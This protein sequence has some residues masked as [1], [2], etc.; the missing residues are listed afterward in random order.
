MVETGY[1][2]ETNS[3]AEWRQGVVAALYGAGRHKDASRFQECG[4]H[5]RLYCSNCGETKK[6]L[7]Y[8]MRR[9]CP[10]CARR[11]SR[12]LQD[13]LLVR[14]KRLKEFENSENRFR[15]RMITLTIKTDGDHDGALSKIGEA[16]PKLWRNLLAR[17]RYSKKVRKGSEVATGWVNS[18]EFGPKTLN[19]HVHG[20]YWG[21]FIR[22]KD[23]SEEWKR[24]TGSCVVDIRVADHKALR[25]VIKYAS[26]FSKISPEGVVLVAE[27]LEGKRRISTYGVFRGVESEAL[28]DLYKMIGIDHLCTR[29]GC[30]DWI[31]EKGLEWLGIRAGPVDDAGV[32]F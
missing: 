9:Y 25:E 10:E 4:V 7:Y 18:I 21:P 8:C 28:D 11:Y 19:V 13:K 31:T 14:L 23:L 29:C 32:F 6:V 5:T 22:Q 1:R 24:L 17:D 3:Y 2:N 26:D 27:S 20:V 16:L 12:K 15:L 30:N